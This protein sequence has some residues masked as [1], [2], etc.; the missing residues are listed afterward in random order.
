MQCNSW[1]NRSAE[2]H[3]QCKETSDFKILCG[4]ININTSIVTTE[5]LWILIKQPHLKS[6]I[7]DTGLQEEE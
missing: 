6:D 5:P 4:F 7:L 1:I 2:S 3:L